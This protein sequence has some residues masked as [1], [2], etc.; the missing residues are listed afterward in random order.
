[1][2]KLVES[3]PSGSRQQLQFELLA[4]TYKGDSPQPAGAM[5]RVVTAD[6][7]AACG[8]PPVID[9]VYVLFARRDDE[10]RLHV[11]TCSGT[12]VHLPPGGDAVG[13]D[14]VPARF[15]AQ[16]LNGMAGIEVLRDV[17]AAA[18]DPGD[19]DNEQLVGLLELNAPAHGG[20]IELRAGPDESLPVLER[21][22]DYEL[23]ESREYGYEVPG[24]VVYAAVAG[25][26]KLRLADGRFA[27]ARKADTGTFFTYAD[28]PLRRLAY[29]TSAW[30]GFAWPSAGAGL[31]LRDPRFGGEQGDYPVE[32]HEVRVVGN[33]PF[34][35]VTVLEQSPCEG[36]GPRE[37]LSGWVPAYG[38]GG[39]PNVWFYSRGC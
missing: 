12:R 31:P 17:A 33:L 10:G 4:A 26:Y 2:A 19:P 32:V 27:W 3:T 16:Q 23:L 36:G 15:V 11:D 9:A 20:W 8:V 29:L 13:F 30:S 14:D 1:M 7:S 38:R 6:H 39:E 5:L 24:A 18:P 35:R 34:F 25:W 28:L 37:R 22:G 21:V